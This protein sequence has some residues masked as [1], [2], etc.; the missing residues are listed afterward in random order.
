V[1][2]GLAQSH[3]QD[4]GAG[5][6][7]SVARHQARPGRH[8]GQ[9]AQPGARRRALSLLRRLDRSPATSKASCS[10]W[11]AWPDSLELAALRRDSPT[12]H[13]RRRVHAVAAHAHTREDDWDSALDST[14]G[15]SRERNNGNLMS[16][17]HPRPTGARWCALFLPLAALFSIPACPGRS[18]RPLQ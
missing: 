10:T 15:L 6:A 12:R 8:P 16:H 5:S 4:R 11:I 2:A 7:G 14:S 17:E 13:G 1:A 18:G 9:L 3:R